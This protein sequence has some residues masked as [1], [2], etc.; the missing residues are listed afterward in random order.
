MASNGLAI[1]GQEKRALERRSA[2][3]VWVVVLEF[4]E[5]LADL[6][7]DLG[8]L[9]ARFPPSAPTITAGLTHRPQRGLR[10]RTKGKVIPW[11]SARDPPM[12]VRRW[13]F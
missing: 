6:L 3:G 13:R 4:R 12:H 7:D 5:P 9:L 1:L 2:C 10:P 8:E 11:A